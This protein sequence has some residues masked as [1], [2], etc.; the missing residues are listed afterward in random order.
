MSLRDYINPEYW[1]Y[2][3]RKQCDQL[4]ALLLVSSG[5]GTI[6][7]EQCCDFETE[8][9]GVLLQS[10]VHPDELESPRGGNA[11]SYLAKVKNVEAVIL[12]LQH[13]QNVSGLPSE[14]LGFLAQCESTMILRRKALDEKLINRI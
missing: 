6:T 9:I 2:F 1:K 13:G 7:D 4:D 3:T 12:L 14:F 8:I 5:N 11:L 10:G